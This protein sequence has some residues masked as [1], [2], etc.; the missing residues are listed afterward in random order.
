MPPPAMDFPDFQVSMGM[1]SQ[2][3]TLALLNDRHTLAL[4]RTYAGL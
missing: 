2:E 4:I 3:K 1:K